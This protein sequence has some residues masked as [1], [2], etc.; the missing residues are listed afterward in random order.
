MSDSPA[1]E[2]S[3]S[4]RNDFPSCACTRDGVGSISRGQLRVRVAEFG[5]GLAG[6]YARTL[7][8]ALNAPV[9]AGAVALAFGACIWALFGITNEESTQP[10]D[11]G[12]VRVFA[13]E[14]D[15]VSLAYSDQ[16]ADRI[17]A[18]RLDVTRCLVHAATVASWAASSVSRTFM[19]L[20]SRSRIRRHRGGYAALNIT[21]PM[22]PGG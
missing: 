20:I 3:G 1:V 2:E 5:R 11:R 22:T 8:L 14:P 9:V 7:R 6:L 15:G 12:V 18:G 4:Y 16:Q 17:E 10:E 21:S 19:H 13:T